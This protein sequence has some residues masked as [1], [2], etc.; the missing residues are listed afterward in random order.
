MEKKTLDCLNLTLA[1]FGGILFLVVE[2]TNISSWMFPELSLCVI[3]NGQGSEYLFN[4][5]TYESE[6]SKIDES[7]NIYGSRKIFSSANPV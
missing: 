6:Y 4:V 1:F 5:N 2:A 7:R 3:I